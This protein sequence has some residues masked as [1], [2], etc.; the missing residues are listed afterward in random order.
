[1]K[2]VKLRNKPA[3]PFFALRARGLF[4]NLTPFIRVSFS[5]LRHSLP[6][7][8]ADAPWIISQGARV[9][10]VLGAHKT[11]KVT[12]KLFKSQIARFHDPKP[13]PC[14]TRLP[15]SPGK[16]LRAYPNNPAARY[17]MRA[18]AK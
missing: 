17:A 7:F 6:L 4:L 3:R 2:G 8:I 9:E 1:M 16:H 12:R 5:S 18:K 11:E 14:G 10:L 15:L 13:H